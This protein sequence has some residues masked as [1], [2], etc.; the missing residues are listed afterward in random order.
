MQKMCVMDEIWQFKDMDGLQAPGI[1]HPGW[2][3]S[4]RAPV[5]APARPVAGRQSL[6]QERPRRVFA[7]HHPDHVLQTSPQPGRVHPGE[8]R[9][10]VWECE[11]QIFWGVA[12]VFNLCH[13]VQ[14]Y[15]WVCVCF[16]SEC[17]NTCMF[18]NLWCV[19][20]HES[21]CLSA[22]LETIMSGRQQCL[23]EWFLHCFVAVVARGVSCWCGCWRCLF[24]SSRPSPEFSCLRSCKNGQFNLMT[25]SCKDICLTLTLKCTQEF[26]LVTFH[27][28]SALTNRQNIQQCELPYTLQFHQDQ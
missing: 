9:A 17:V 8:V 10:R 3:G 28:Y 6:L 26:V 21:D 23:E 2:P 18:V 7:L 11:S 19:C 12:A 27:S 16:E 1:Q 13:C 15:A 5:A 25:S 22:K 24:S 4:P 20:N 14:V